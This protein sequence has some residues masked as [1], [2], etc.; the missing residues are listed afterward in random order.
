MNSQ[1]AKKFEQI[2]SHQKMTTTFSLLNVIVMYVTTFF[3]VQ[4]DYDRYVFIIK[5]CETS[6]LLNCLFINFMK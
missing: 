1:D 6:H 4:F 5:I 2:Q 3:S